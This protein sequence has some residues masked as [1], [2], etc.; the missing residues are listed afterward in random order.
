MNMWNFAKSDREGTNNNVKRPETVC[1]KDL[2]GLLEK[3][4]LQ[5]NFLI[6]AV[7]E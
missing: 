3:H 5:G 6:N 1:N 7:N 4:V 2:G